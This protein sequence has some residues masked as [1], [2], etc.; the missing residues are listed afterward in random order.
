MNR[1]VLLKILERLGSRADSVPNGREVLERLARQPC[2]LIL[3]DIQL[4][5]LDGLEAT[6]RLHTV[7]PSDAAPYILAL[8]ANARKEDYH[9]CLDAGMQDYLSKPV[10]TDDLMAAMVRADDWL[11]FDHRATLAVA[12]PQLG[13]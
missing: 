8:T 12:W 6:R 13:A 11:Q 4:P 5:E 1:K 10:R 2:D 3:M 9:A 7:M